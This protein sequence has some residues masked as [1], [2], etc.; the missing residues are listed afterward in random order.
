MTIRYPTDT[1][2]ERVDAD[3][4]TPVRDVLWLVDD[5][6]LERDLAQN[7][8]QSRYSVRTFAD[9]ESMLEEL[10]QRPTPPDV[11]LVDF[12]MPGLTGLDVCRFVRQTFSEGRLPVIILT[13]ST[14]EADLVESLAAGANDFATKP[15]KTAELLAR[16]ATHIRNKRMHEKLEQAEVALRAEADLRE[17]FVG[18]LGHDLR[19]PI[20]TVLMGSHL[21]QREALSPLALTTVRRM[22]N[23]SQL[24]QRMVA[25][26]LDFTRIRHGG[27]I[28]V[29]LVEADLHAIVR[30]VVDGLRLGH[31]ERTVDLQMAG[32]GAGLWDADRMAQLCGNLVGNALDYSPAGS[33][34][35]VA[36]RDSAAGVEVEVTNEGPPILPQLLST[37]F[38]PFKRGGRA[39]SKGVG[40]GLF[41]AEQVARAHGGTIT[42]ESDTTCTRFVARL[43]RDRTILR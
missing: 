33:V 29:S 30:R 19:Q 6:P 15:F 24:M 13:S 5:S 27:G 18:I 32:D 34:V 10:F 26:L 4:T 23:A 41:I 8:L 12:F 9:G 42:V 11:L 31:P 1:Q 14:D 25:D 21:L 17:R 40:L 22:A 37:L 3:R 39:H 16:V 7:A 2:A 38:D 28:P 36:V 35:H 43:R 20:Q